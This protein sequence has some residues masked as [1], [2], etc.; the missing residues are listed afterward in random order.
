MPFWSPK[1]RATAVVLRNEGYTYEE[2]ASKIGGTKSGVRKV[3][4][5]FQE[6]G[7]VIDRPRSGRKK[8]T[9]VYDDRKLIRTS[10]KDRRRTSKEIA[11]DLNA[12]GVTA[13]AQT[14][15]RRL[16]SFGL[17]ARIPRKKP[18]LTLVQHMKRVKWA[19]EH[20]KWT[21]QKWRHVIFSD[22]S[23]ISIFGSD[24]IRYVRRRATEEFLPQCILPTM[25]HPQSI[26]VW[27][28]MSGEGIGRLQVCEG[29]IT[30]RKYIDDILEKKLRPSA[31]DMFGL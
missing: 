19:K 20:S 2:I 1:K 8:V 22:E 3:F 28:C 16:T 14:V 7:K 6:S 4:L 25:K 27:G 24:G 9:T 17:K 31:A 23:R 26:M 30:A 29:M 13:S 5:K 12:S 10:L 15:R 11:N 21:V 18:Y